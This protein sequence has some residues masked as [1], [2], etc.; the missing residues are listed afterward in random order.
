MLSHRDVGLAPN[1]DLLPDGSRF[2][3][4][5]SH[6]ED[7]R[8]S[9]ATVPLGAARHDDLDDSHDSPSFIYDLDGLDA[10]CHPH[11]QG[12][13]SAVVASHAFLRLFND[14]TTTATGRA[15]LLDGSVPKGP[16]TWLRRLPI[17][18]IDALRTPFFAFQ[19]PRHFP[20]A[21]AID[22]LLLPPVQGGDSCS[23]L[24]KSV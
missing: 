1:H 19:D 22:L 24:L 14:P 13:A 11:A 23:L 2:P 16:S 6:L 18:S 15:R 8:L 20:I 7:G 4:L 12:A 9:P 5:H 10:T 21:L 17:P 3:Q